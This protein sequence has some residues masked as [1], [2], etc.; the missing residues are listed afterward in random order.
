MVSHREKVNKYQ[1]RQEIDQ[2]I[3]NTIFFDFQV[4][5]PGRSDSYNTNSVLVSY[6]VALQK[7]V[8]HITIQFHNQ[9][10]HA[11]KRHTQSS[12]DADNSNAFP[13]IGNKKE[14]RHKK[15][16]TSIRFPMKNPPSFIISPMTSQFYDVQKCNSVQIV[17]ST[18]VVQKVNC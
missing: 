7:K 16:A 1:V 8:T 12:Y 2:T 10:Q 15:Q 6:I 11:V 17:Y 18:Y 4:E 13:V 3:N 5:K 9:P 14:E